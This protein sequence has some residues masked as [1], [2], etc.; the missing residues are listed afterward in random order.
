MAC[1]RFRVYGIPLIMFPCPHSV[2]TAT[3]RQKVVYPSSCFHAYTVCLQLPPGKKWT[4]LFVSSSG[5]K[6]YPT[7]FQLPLASWA[8][9]D[10]NLVGLRNDPLNENL[11]FIPLTKWTCNREWK[12]DTSRQQ[13]CA[14]MT[15]KYQ[16]TIFQPPFLPFFSIKLHCSSSPLCFNFTNLITPGLYMCTRKLH[17]MTEQDWNR[18]ETVEPKH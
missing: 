17:F 13:K 12:R 10:E 11:F 4:L 3:P 15:V 14:N 16:Q 2:F 6:S 8:K 18:T 9:T 1:F 7:G 5:M